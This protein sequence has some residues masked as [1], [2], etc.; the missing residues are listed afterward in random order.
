MIGRFRD[1]ETGQTSRVPKGAITS[2]VGLTAELR[3]LAVFLTI[4]V[5]GSQASIL[6]TPTHGRVRQHVLTAGSS[7]V[8]ILTAVRN[9]RP[10]TD[11]EWNEI[12]GPVS[13]R[14]FR[15]L[16]SIKHWDNSRKVAERRRYNEKHPDSP[17][18]LKQFKCQERDPKD[19]SDTDDTDEEWRS[20]VGHFDR[21][22]PI[23]PHA[24][25]HLT[26]QVKWGG[27]HRFND[28]VDVESKHRISLKS[29]GGKI[30]IR[31]DTQTEKDLLRCVQEEVV[32]A[33]LDE[34]I[35][36][37]AEDPGG[38]TIAEE[39][40]EYQKENDVP[41]QLEI[42]SLTAPLHVDK[43]VDRDHHGRLVDREVLL[44]WGELFHKFSHCFPA[45]ANDR[46]QDETKWSLHQHA[47]HDMK[48]GTRYHYWCT[49][50]RYPV[51]QR[52]GSRRRRDMVRV[53]GIDGDEHLA[54]IVTVVSARHPN[55][56]TPD[57][58]PEVGV[59]VRWL[60][61][62]KDAIM[63]DNEPTCPG[64][65]SRSHNL[66]SWHR[67]DVRRSAISGYHYGRLSDTQ[68]KWLEPESKR[69]SLLFA[70]YDVVE[71]QS[72]GKYANVAPDFDTGDITC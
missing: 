67:T 21:S 44:S 52:G 7:L 72:I 65:L 69:E 37:T 8:L 31:T 71:F 36:E 34:L 33:T 12:F 4:H 55:P 20:L 61:P 68:K 3:V 64:P 13:L 32:F 39:I 16:D 5:L 51:I 24:V 49:D 29:H 2:Q 23:L 59:L 11:R 28:T 47:V 63:Y 62:H 40:K 41:N 18:K 26:S 6:D 57:T 46:V 38:I 60:T 50:T 48:Y 54:Q 10:Y 42:I 27:T 66:W 45:F 25:V 53:S 15:A 58:P 17:K 56:P 1:P 9:K 30:R 70:S 14:Y 43:C 22:G 19:S 35:E